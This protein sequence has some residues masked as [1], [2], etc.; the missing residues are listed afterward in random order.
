MVAE[1]VGWGKCL[2]GGFSLISYAHICQ[3]AHVCLCSSAACVFV[4]LKVCVCL[5]VCVAQSERLTV[6]LADERW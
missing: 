2:S 4:C 3:A 5:C 6:V 1:G